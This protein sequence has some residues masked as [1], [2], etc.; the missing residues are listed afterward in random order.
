MKRK[1]QYRLNRNIYSNSTIEMG[2]KHLYFSDKVFR[3]SPEKFEDRY[4]LALTLTYNSA[5]KTSCV[6][7]AN[8]NLE[9]VYRHIKDFV[10]EGNR[11]KTHLNPT[12]YG[13]LD[14]PGTKWGFVD[15]ERVY[16]GSCPLQWCNWT[17]LVP[18]SP[19]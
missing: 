14:A 3:C 6:S 11:N 9:R 4:I 1:S 7:V 19:A 13:F 2:R 18:C 10:T 12:M 16:D 8:E 5:R 15:L 17:A